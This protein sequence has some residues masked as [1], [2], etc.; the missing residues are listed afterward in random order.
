MSCRLTAETAVQQSGSSVQKAP[1]VWQQETKTVLPSGSFLGI[2]VTLKQKSVTQRTKTSLR[3]WTSCTKCFSSLYSFYLPVGHDL[4]HFLWG[5]LLWKPKPFFLKKKKQ[6]SPMRMKSSSSNLKSAQS[7][8]LRAGWHQDTVH[9][10]N[11]VG[12]LWCQEKI[13]F[14]HG[15][16]ANLSK[17]SWG[18]VRQAVNSPG[19]DAA[20]FRQKQSHR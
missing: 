3:K 8:S 20:G 18:T 2:S 4:L 10:N 5:I 16:E 11:A 12:S 14:M 15:D 19:G 7:E 1:W 13:V 17:T 9:Q 6:R